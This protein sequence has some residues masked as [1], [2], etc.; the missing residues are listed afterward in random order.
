MAEAIDQEY[1]A[2]VNM[3]RLKEEYP[4]NIKKFYR[5]GFTRT[6]EDRSV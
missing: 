4:V 2:Y 5:Q 6:H 3:C 1:D